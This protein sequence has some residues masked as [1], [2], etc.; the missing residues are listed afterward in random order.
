[1]SKFDMAARLGRL[2][3][4]GKEPAS[5]GPVFVSMND[6][7]VHRLRDV[8]SVWL[9]ALRLRQAWPRTEGA[10]GLW[11]FSLSARRSVSVSIWRNANDI[12]GFVHSPAHTDVMRRHKRTGD[13]ITLQW[14]AERFDKHLIFTQALERLATSRGP[15]A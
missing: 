4:R 8:P 1:M 9:D 7:V 14:T 2:W 15:V 6:Y 3:K 5:G 11:F 10:L 12:K 13:L